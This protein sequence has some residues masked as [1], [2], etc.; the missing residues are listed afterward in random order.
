MRDSS[1]RIHS[2]SQRELGHEQWVKHWMDEFLKS[3]TGYVQPAPCT[4]R[5]KHTD[6]L[7]ILDISIHAPDFEEK[8]LPYGSHRRITEVRT[9]IDVVG[10]LEAEFRSQKGRFVVSGKSHPRHTR[11]GASH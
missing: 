10:S 5:D 4:Q 11:Q 1:T 8:V 2:V 6:I 7:L 3:D 9:P